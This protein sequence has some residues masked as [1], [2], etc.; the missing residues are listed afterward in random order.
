M[1]TYVYL[2]IFAESTYEV[3]LRHTQIYEDR[4]DEVKE[5]E[6]LVNR[7]NRGIMPN[8]EIM[9]STIERQISNTQLKCVGYE[10]LYQHLQELPNTIISLQYAPKVFLT[11]NVREAK[12]GR[13]VSEG[14]RDIAFECQIRGTTYTFTRKHLEQ[15]SKREFNE[16]FEYLRLN[17]GN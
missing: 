4:I 2:R 14:L 10:E 15:M 8:Q 7:P 16:L 6:A 13:V 5:E 17:I 9:Q 11:F 12:L 3:W 1:G